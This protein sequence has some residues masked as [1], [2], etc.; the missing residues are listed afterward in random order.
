[1]ADGAVK[2]FR[3]GACL[4][5]GRDFFGLPF[6]SAKEMDSER[7]KRITMIVFLASK[8]KWSSKVTGAWGGA[9]TDG[10]DMRDL[11]RTFFSKLSYK[12][13]CQKKLTLLNENLR[14]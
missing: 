12:D 10:K 13:C 3:W 2:S 4:P 8:T 14:N 7:C 9:P 6:L 1:M 5:A 11:H